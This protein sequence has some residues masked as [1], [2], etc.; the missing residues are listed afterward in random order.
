M[1]IWQGWGKFAGAPFHVRRPQGLRARR[2]WH[3]CSS[4]ALGR[5]KTGCCRSTAEPLARLTGP[6]LNGHTPA[7]SVVLPTREEA[8]NVGPLVARLE[9]VLPDL[10]VEI[11]FVDD[12]DDETPDAIRAIDSSR[13]VYLIHRR[14]RRAR[15][16]PRGRRGGG[17]PGR[18]RAARVRDGRRPPA[19][20]GAARGDVP[21]GDGD[22][23]GPGRRQPVL[24]GWRQGHLQPHALG[25][26]AR[27]H[28]RRGD[29]VPD[30]AV[31]RD[32]TR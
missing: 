18:T 6:D 30:A 22:G 26:L 2:A 31:A 3:T 27:L 29:A 5:A 1:W 17:H 13:A 28:A 4:C 10:P 20:A 12:S 21:R 7:I 24:R 19:P 8:E 25:A 14:A 11:I 23:L 15:R 9:R 16:R 32:A